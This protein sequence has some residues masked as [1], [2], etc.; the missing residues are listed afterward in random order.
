MA[1]TI[2]VQEEDAEDHAD[3]HPAQDE[4]D[5]LIDP[6]GCLLIDLVVDHALLHMAGDGIVAAAAE[7]LSE[8]IDP[9]GASTISGSAGSA[10]RLQVNSHLCNSMPSVFTDSSIRKRSIGSD[11]GFS[12]ELA[13]THRKVS[14]TKCST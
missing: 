1:G 7:E 14:D 2:L 10:R 4:G 9:S 11:E 3:G 5:V 13:A 8:N 6:G 12:N